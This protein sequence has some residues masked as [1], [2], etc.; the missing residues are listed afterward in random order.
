MIKIIMRISVLI[1]LLII[2]TMAFCQKKD[3]VES[4]RIAMKIKGTDVAHKKYYKGLDTIPFTG[5]VV[6]RYPE[7]KKL[8]RITEIKDGIYADGAV[9]EYFENGNKKSEVIF[10]KGVRAGKYK[11][12]F[13]N[14]KLKVEDGF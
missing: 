6:D 13:E 10:Q 4:S 9:T 7:S 8:S 11:E 14:G 3:T 5:V 12:W 2:S 1:F